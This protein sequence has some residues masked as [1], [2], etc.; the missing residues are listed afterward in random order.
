MQLIEA[1]RGRRSATRLTDPA[2][3]DNEI[4]ELMA[5]A[6]T[7]PDHGLLR[8]WRLVLVR[9]A[10]R[11]ALGAAFA[12]DLPEADAVGKA[13]AAGKPLRAPLLIAIVCSPRDAPKVPDWEQMAA[14]AIVVYTL[15]LLLHERGWGAMWRTGEPARSVSVRAL[16]GVGDREH[17]LG[18]LYVGTSSGHC[19]PDRPKLDVRQQTFKLGPDDTI[20]PLTSTA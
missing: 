14:T 15:M 5:D 18:W 13:R 11:E 9:G 20:L 12:A 17:L 16:L 4:C 19:P 2:P 6:A 7:G 10:A 3:T 8:P 1:M